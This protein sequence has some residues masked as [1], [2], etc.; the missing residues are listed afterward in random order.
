MVVLFWGVVIAITMTLRLKLIVPPR[1][2]VLA[3]VVPVI[4]VRVRVRIVV[5]AVAVVGCIIVAAVAFML[6]LVAG[7]H[8]RLKGWL[9]FRA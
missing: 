4:V 2:W 1:A 3:G 7:V 6:G 8:C 5:V 9:V